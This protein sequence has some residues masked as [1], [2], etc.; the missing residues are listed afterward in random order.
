MD[1]PSNA[2]DPHLMKWL[3]DKT[4]E[5]NN[6]EIDEQEETK[7]KEQIIVM[8]LHTR[9]STI[10]TCLEH[11]LSHEMV[12]QEEKATLLKKSLISSN[13]ILIVTSKLEVE[14]WAG[15]IRD[16]PWAR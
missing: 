10:A 8:S 7:N 12:N 11:W 16:M 2:I 14:E 9:P 6:D 4:I 15:Y 5:Y 3:I 1:H 13:A